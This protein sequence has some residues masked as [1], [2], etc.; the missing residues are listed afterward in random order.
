M[1]DPL[2]SIIVCVRNGM[3]HVREAIE[4][5][6][7]QTYVRYELVIQDGASTDGTKEYLEQLTGFPSMSVES[8]P[9]GG[10]GQGLNRALRRC[11]GT[12][13]GSV[14][15]DNRMH[16]GAVEA[17]VH[18]FNAHPGA[19]V[20][21]G[22]CNMIDERGNLLHPYLPAKF[23]LLGL[24]NGSVVPPFGTSYFRPAICGDRLYFD[25]DFPVVPDFAL[26]LR[27]S[28]LEIVRITDVL[29]DVRAGKQSS[30]YQPES[31]EQQ[32][33]YKLLAAKRFLTD[34]RR[35]RALNALAE[36]AEAGISLWAADS[37]NVIGAQ[38][39]KVNYYFQRALRG[40]LRTE[41]FRSVVARAQPKILDLDGEIESE[42]LMCGIECQL[43][44]K[45]EDALVYFE[46]LERS[47]SAR[48]EL[49]DLIAQS[50]KT[51]KEIHL[52]H[53]MD[54]IDALQAKMN[55]EVDLRDR[56][57]VEMHDHLQGEIDFRDRLLEEERRARRTLVMKMRESLKLG[58]RVR[59]FFALFQ[60]R[61]RS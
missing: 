30:T 60:G 10:M 12:I 40:D 20:V 19:A 29:L 41:H 21:Y 13:I 26:W 36:R 49:P 15:A 44:L 55:F 43:R 42:V 22:A 35:V 9:D 39:E 11:K 61:S 56:R 46:L 16:P 23:D 7:A 34:Q 14:D 6:R 45:P 50:R 28:D 59:R 3:P 2:V 37:M 53:S 52:T 8:A 17:A 32:T 48:P 18:A 4:S 38:K 33:H 51:A 31:Y 24:L 57:L 27:L 47:G 54:V 25:E 5:V 58:E 1:S